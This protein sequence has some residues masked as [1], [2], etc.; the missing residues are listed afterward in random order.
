MKII[1]TPLKDL[2]IIEPNVFEDARGY[3]ME[4]Y[5]QSVLEPSSGSF[6]IIQENESFSRR[7]ALRGLHYQA[8]PFAQAKLVR[9]IQGEVLDV[10]VDI[11]KDSPTYLKSYSVVLSDKNKLQ[12]FV[13]KGFAH[14]FITLSE[15]ALFSYK[16]DAPYAPQSEGG[17]YWN[18]P[19]L[20][21]DWRLNGLDYIISEKD[22]KLP[23]ISQWE[24]PFE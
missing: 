21:I 11:R 15:T 9:C 24:S 13:P 3:F 7:G 12:I 19:S 8:P 17:I 2:V 18:D 16:V 10:C 14:G 1:E 4:S 20:D 6:H 5:K 23:N 22:S